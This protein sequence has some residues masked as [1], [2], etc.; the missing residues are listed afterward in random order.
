MIM[1]TK[2]EKEIFIIINIIWNKI[3]RN[4]KREIRREYWV[5][6]QK[7]AITSDLEQKIPITSNYPEVKYRSKQ[8]STYMRNS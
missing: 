5:V 8:L 7:I 6:L 3:Q 4:E 2:T 1:K